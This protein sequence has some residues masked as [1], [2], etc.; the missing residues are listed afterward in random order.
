MPETV[1]RSRPPRTR[2]AERAEQTRRRIIDAATALFTEVGY[3]GTTIE[4]I[5]G[6]A[7]VAVETVYS[8]F[9]N[10]L[11]LLDAILGPAIR[12]SDDGRAFSAQPE[13]AE[14]RACT[15]QRQQ[16]T[17]LAHFSR[18]V[19]QRSAQ[20]HRILRTA[21][22]SDPKAAALE[23]S[24]Q[25]SRRRGQELYIDLLLANGPLRDGLTK[26]DAADTYA[27]LASPETYAFLT[28][29]RGWTPDRFEAWLADG[30]TLL[31]LP[32]DPSIRTPS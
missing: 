26:A 12:G 5:A 16:A 23:Q 6:R 17:L 10:K 31:L 29:Q 19:L 22:A 27:A 18:T 13:L 21:A 2:R 7:D 14:I 20:A 32:L 3:A 30:L 8:R 1:K 11:G 28:E 25:E 4:A 15:D 24:D 9:R